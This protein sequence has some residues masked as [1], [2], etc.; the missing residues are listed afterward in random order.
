[1]IHTLKDLHFILFVPFIQK[2]NLNEYKLKL[3]TQLLI[4][5]YRKV[6]KDLFSSIWGETRYDNNF[7][8]NLG[9]AW[10]PLISAP[11]GRGST[12]WVTY[13]D[14][15]KQSKSRQK[16]IYRTISKDHSLL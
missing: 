13:W 15:E 3:S 9:Q 12:V 10:Y 8:I 11:E 1:M 4:L 6:T 2:L 5:L 7:K 16:I 14:T